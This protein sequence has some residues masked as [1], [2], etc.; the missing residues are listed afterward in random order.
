M[1]NAAGSPIK[2]K[3]FSGYEVFMIAI[4]AILQFTVILDFMVLSPLGAILLEKLQIRTS[5][6]GLVVSS[7]AF[8]AGASGILAAG[9]ADRFDRKKMLLFF[10][11]GF[12]GGTYLCALA[13]TYELLLVA[14]II[15][16]LF[17]GVISSVSLAIISD[18]FKLEVRGRVMGFV[19]MGFAASQV[20]G[21]PVGLTL[22][23]H[24]GWHAP[25]WMIALFGTLLG[26]LIYFKM[27]PVDTHLL[28]KNEKNAFQ[29]LFHT[30]THTHYPLA[31][32][33]TTLLATGGFMLMP[34]GSAFTIH[35]MGL[36]MEQLPVLYG[37]TGIF[38]IMMGP[39]IGRLSDQI[40]K[41]KT[42]CIGSVITIIMVFIYTRLGITSLPIAILINIILFMGI[43]SRSV[44]SSALSTAVP[45]P[46][47]RGAFMSINAA[48]QQISG[49]IAAAVAGLIVVQ[50]GSGRIL[51]YDTVG[52]VVIGSVIISAIL[53]YSINKYVHEKH[54]PNKT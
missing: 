23:N 28:V 37:V 38:T 16:G 29:H 2:I 39:L 42:F 43:L 8:S 51:H 34:F 36:S 21:I 7:Y 33:A 18:I 5:Q 24:Y 25:F 19:Q 31:F 11:S 9:F 13:P 32:L 12:I 45:E 50:S 10:Y 41:Y 46:Q 15:T 40:G 17:G 53:L 26:I 27:Q 49:G 30:V 20:L 48:V 44:S 6:F 22:A 35:N 54:Q 47:D 1:N 52:Y 3:R 4:L 14:R